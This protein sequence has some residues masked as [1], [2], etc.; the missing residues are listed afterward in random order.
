M[1]QATTSTVGR[2]MFRFYSI[3]FRDHLEAANAAPRTIETYGLAVDQLGEY[4]RTQGMPTNPTDVT[5]E[6]LI[7]WMR[8]LQRPA[9]E[10]GREV[11]AATAN[12]RYRSISRFFKFLLEQEEITQNPLAKMTPPKVPEKLVPVVKTVDLSRV[13]K[14]LAGTD[15]E[16]RRDRA[17]FSLFIDTGLRVSEMAGLTLADLDLEDRE[18]EVIQGKGRKSRRLR[19]ARETRTD[20]QRYLLRRGEHPHAEDE[21]LWIG[22]RGAVTKSGM[23]R[24]VIRRCEQADIGHVYPHMLRHTFAHMYRLNG[25]SDDD[26]MRVAG[27]KSREMLSRYGASVAEARAAEAHDAHSPRRGL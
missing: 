26:L 12:Q 19:F 6:H 24:L 4:L 2:D 10:G 11:S 9:A 21:A 5:R 25:G 13:L 18:I 17:I 16:A 3:M 15:F 23:Y 1:Q 8:Y 20:I 14:S 7:E 27:W 22:K